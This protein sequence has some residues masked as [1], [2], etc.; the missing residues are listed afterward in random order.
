MRPVYLEA[1]VSAAADVAEAVVIP[2]A[3][4]SAAAVVVIPDAE[5]SA[6]TAGQLF[7]THERESLSLGVVQ[8][9][10]CSVSCQLHAILFDA[11]DSSCSSSLSSR[12]C[13]CLPSLLHLLVLLLIR[14]LIIIPLV[15]SFEYLYSLSSSSPSSLFSSYSYSCRSMFSSSFFLFSLSPSYAF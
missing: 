5:V 2:D 14:I 6:S 12:A 1:E 13:P 10:T 11:S 15:S 3:E 8:Q 9:N 7:M 4:V